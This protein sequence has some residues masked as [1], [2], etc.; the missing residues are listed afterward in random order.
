VRVY[1]Y[2]DAPIDIGAFRFMGVSVKSESAIGKFGT[3]LK[4]A[5][6]VLIRNGCGFSVTICGRVWEAA[7]REIAIRGKSFTTVSLVS[8][9]DYI[10]LPI[11]TELG[12]EWSVKEA[13]RELISNTMDEGGGFGEDPKPL[14]TL[15]SV[16]GVSETDW[17]NAKLMFLNADG[18]DL[19]KRI[20]NFDVYTTVSNALYFKGVEV[21]RSS[22]PFSNTYN[23]HGGLMISEDRALKY[24]SIEIGSLVRKLVRADA[25]YLLERAL[26]PESAEYE[27]SWPT[28][29][30]S[31]SKQSIDVIARLISTGK[32][33]PQGVL[34]AFKDLV[35]RGSEVSIVSL[36]EIPKKNLLE[37]IE[38]VRHVNAA[39]LQFEIAISR[40]IPGN[41]MGF[42]DRSNM[43]IVLS[44]H[45]LNSGVQQI[46]GTILEEFFHLKHNVDDCTREFQNLL[47]DALATSYVCIFRSR[48]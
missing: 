30:A 33:V 8:R 44:E 48:Q 22:R 32:D 7:P 13:L 27:A 11:T 42:A 45:V 37:A 38:V 1:F 25:P 31:Y 9:G 6:A 20:E 43:K 17:D 40:N 10:D 36:G 15:I 3:G 24:P 46:V 16:D 39:A 5:I 34:M 2:N 4:Y 14:D 41:V 23:A 29:I 19:V 28:T 12:N 21:F 26:E 47:V 35:V 18:M